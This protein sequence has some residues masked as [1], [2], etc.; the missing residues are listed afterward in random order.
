[1]AE[2]T[3]QTEVL[4]ARRQLPHAEEEEVTIGNVNSVVSDD[5]L[6][7]VFPDYV[8]TTRNRRQSVTYLASKGRTRF[9]LDC[10]S[11]AMRMAMPMA[12]RIFYIDDFKQKR[13]PKEESCSEFSKAFSD[14]NLQAPK[15]AMFNE[16][17]KEF[18][19]LSDSE[20]DLQVLKTRFASLAKCGAI[21]DVERMAL[22]AQLNTYNRRLEGK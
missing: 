9:M 17:N 14:Q 10:Q 2:V 7:S 21:L 6:F 16:L 4:A 1:M 5:M 3:V 8:Q 18:T 20:T 22:T 13:L 12:Y 19:D 15:D 11:V